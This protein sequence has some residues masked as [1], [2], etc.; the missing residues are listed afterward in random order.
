LIFESTINSSR[1]GLSQSLSH[2]RSTGLTD[3]R[4]LDEGPFLRMTLLQLAHQQAVRQE[5]QIHVAGLPLAF[6]DLTIPHAQMLLAIPM[7]GLRAGPAMPIHH[8]DPDDFPVGAVGHQN[9]DS[10]V[11][12]P[13]PGWAKQGIMRPK[14]P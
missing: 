2:H 11:K 10:L 3:G 7:E 12:T 1:E 14:R 8:Q 5:D 9:L 4:Q 6:P 13:W